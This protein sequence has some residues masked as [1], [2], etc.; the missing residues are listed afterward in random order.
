V[1]LGDISTAAGRDL[2]TKPCNDHASKASGSATFLPCIVTNYS[3]VYSLFK[4]AYSKHGRIDHAIS[5]AGILERGNFF[6][7]PSATIESVANDQGGASVFD[8]KLIGLL[9]FARIAT[10][11]LRQPSEPDA[12]RTH[13]STTFLSWIAGLRDS[14]GMPLY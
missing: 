5:C 1:F 11:F 8:V 14:P 10:L 13:K 12:E 2:E 7:D 6:T 3:G 9:N 4:S